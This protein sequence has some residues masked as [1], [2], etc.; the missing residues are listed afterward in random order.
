MKNRKDANSGASPDT[1]DLGCARQ[2]FIDHAAIALHAPAV[3][4][5]AV[6]R[7]ADELWEARVEWMA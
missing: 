4:L 1:A 6:F 2:S 5:V 7:K 3:P